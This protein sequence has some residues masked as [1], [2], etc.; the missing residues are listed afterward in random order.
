MTCLIS[1]TRLIF[2]TVLAL[3]LLG[4]AANGESK[5]QPWEEKACAELYD[6]IGLFTHLSDLE[7]KAKNE[8]RASLY[9]SVAAN[10]A[11]IYQTVCDTK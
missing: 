1:M 6:S 4:M 10:Y 11:I 7:W 3:S 2:T 5:N 8:E 9:A